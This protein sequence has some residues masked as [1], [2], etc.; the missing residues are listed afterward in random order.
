MSTNETE[1]MKYIKNQTSYL[2]ADSISN[3]VPTENESSRSKKNNKKQAPKS[4]VKKS[5]ITKE[6]LCVEDSVI[7]EV[8]K[9]FEDHLDDETTADNQDVVTAKS[10]KT[11]PT[12]IHYVE[13]RKRQKDLFLTSGLSNWP[14]H[15]VLEL[16][17][18]FSIDRK[19]TKQI[20][21]DLLT[22]FKTL[23]C[24]FEASY[25]ELVQVNG[26]GMQSAI[27]IMLVYAIMQRLLLE[28]SNSNMKIKNTQSA[29][30]VLYPHFMTQSVECSK[31]MCLDGDRNLL[32]VRDLGEGT[33]LQTPVD[34]RRVIKSA[35]NTNTVYVYLVHNHISSPLEPS[36]SDWKTTEE[37]S[38]VLHSLDL[39]LLDHIIIGKT[40]NEFASLRQLHTSQQY[41]I[42][43]G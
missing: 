2:D 14:D 17:L 3:D 13:H 7:S 40:H 19:D 37:L 15:H 23:Q 20:A 42:H 30:E 22:Q 41:Q 34:F 27:L 1:Y 11:M 28:Q 24:V 18:F 43:W 29:Y 9:I 35:I 39:Y 38:K 33:I 8:T 32:A 36:H 16:L 26:I 6:K 25:D 31:I 4:K 12:S 21:R 10:K 5:S